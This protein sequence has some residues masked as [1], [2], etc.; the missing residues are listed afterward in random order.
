VKSG[1]GASPADAAVTAALLWINLAGR[2]KRRNH[3]G[4]FMRLIMQ[5]LLDATNIARPQSFVLTR[6]RLTSERATKSPVNEAPA[7]C[8][9]GVLLA[10]R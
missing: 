6:D 3:D 5:T 4:C 1:I 8:G 9:A 7:C 10:V 2:A